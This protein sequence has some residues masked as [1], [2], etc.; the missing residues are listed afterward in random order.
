MTDENFYQSPTWQDLIKRSKNGMNTGWM[1]NLTNY[2]FRKEW[3]LYDLNNDIFEN[4]NLAYNV[5]YSNILNQLKFE[6]QKWQNQ[7]NDPWICDNTDYVCFQPY[8]WQQL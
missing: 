6:L 5:S 1:Y 7:T 4:N 3:E 8:Q 2:Y